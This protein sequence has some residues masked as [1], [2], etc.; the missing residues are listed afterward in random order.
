M[1][2][3]DYLD[4]LDQLLSGSNPSREQVLGMMDETMSFFREIKAKLESNDPA[5]QKEA[6]EETMAMKG[7]LESKMRAMAEKSGLNLAELAAFVE[8]AN[9]MP[10]EDM[11]TLA[12]V[13]AKLSQIQK[14]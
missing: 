5:T 4:S 11:D 1:N 2:N 10:S 6:F 13:K 14:E 12:T 9:N 7:I 3:N 8:N